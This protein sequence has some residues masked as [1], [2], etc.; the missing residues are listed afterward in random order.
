MISSP[1]AAGHGEGYTAVSTLDAGVL[2]RTTMLSWEQL[3]TLAAAPAPLESPYRDG[4]A[5]A[6]FLERLAR[7]LDRR[8]EALIHAMRHETGFIPSDCDEVFA[9]VLA[10]LHG[11]PASDPNDVSPRE[12]AKL[13]NGRVAQFASAPW[14][15][16]CV[17]L[18]QNAFLYLAAVCLAAA[19][20]AGNRVVLRAPSQSALSA[21][22][23]AETLQDAGADWEHAAVVTA[24][25]KEFVTAF[26][27][28][29]Q[30]GLIHYMGSSR[31][32]PAILSDSFKAGK[33]S[34]VDGDGNA[35]V[36][37]G[38]QI[39]PDAAAR[40][41]TQGA[42]RYNGQTCTSINGAVIHPQIYDAVRRTLLKHWE[43]L[44][45][46]NTLDDPRTDVGP[47]L[48]ADQALWCEQQL[49]QSGGTLLQGGHSSGNLLTP[50][51]LEA[52][53]PH[54]SLVREGLFGPAL[55]ITEGDA[56]QFAEIWRHNKYPLCAGVIGAEQAPEWWLSRLPGV[57]R[58]VVDGDPSIE[59]I[60]EPWGGYLGS[61]SN[62]VG[63]W[64]SKYRRVLQI[65]RP[66]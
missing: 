18:P 13:Q 9:G 42:I 23:L 57:A 17:V 66:E 36:Y 16:I 39:D 25:S 38:P 27:E 32:A 62:P 50:A 26:Q 5:L 43:A 3:Q 33:A 52:P 37:L 30:P 19:L 59:D 28:S 46:G 4:A 22:L 15:T 51:L 29:T 2:H 35:I 55:W 45:F 54:S 21:M 7:Q 8:R 53:D 48:S 47:L 12:S 1:I 41:L 11:F 60:F 56:G 64:T 10:L 34:I 49:A 61:G 20:A 6:A 40:I 58:L 63:D 65:D 44:T 31:H 24:K 14:G